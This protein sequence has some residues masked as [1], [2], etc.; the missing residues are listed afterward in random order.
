MAVETTDAR[1]RTSSTEH[2]PR[3]STTRPMGR[4]WE[5]PY[6]LALVA[7]D[8]TAVVTSIAVGSWAHS[9]FFVAGSNIVAT[10][11]SFVLALPLVW[12][13]AMATTRAYEPRY[14]GLGSEEFH[15]V[16]RASVWVFA[17]VGTYSWATQAEVAR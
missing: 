12:V 8:V 9:Q 15:R 10:Y 16:A 13:L 4:R 17:M 2:E 11:R 5:R 6:V 1:V 7:L 3:V 14:L